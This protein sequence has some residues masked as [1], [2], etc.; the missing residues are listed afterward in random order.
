MTPMVCIGIV[1]VS[2]PMKM[3]SSPLSLRI[4]LLPVSRII[5]VQCL[6]HY[7]SALIM[8]TTNVATGSLPM[9]AAF[10]PAV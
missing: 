2:P 6:A 4:S 5:S 7:S 1:E 9:A 8:S 3:Q 10:T